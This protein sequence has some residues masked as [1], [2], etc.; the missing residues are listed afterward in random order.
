VNRAALVNDDAHVRRALRQLAGVNPKGQHHETR[1]VH[2]FAARMPLSVAEHF[3]RELAQPNAVVLDPMVGSGTTAVAT[4]RL[5]RSAVGI[6]RDPLA[7]LI[8]R[9]VT[10]TYSLKLVLQVSE[11][12][13][14]RARLLLPRKRAP[15][16]ATDET[17]QFIEYWFPVEAQQQLAA[18]AE[19]IMNEP[20]GAGRDFAWLV[21]SSSIIA[22]SAGASWAMDISRSRPHKREDKGVVLPFEAWSQRCT[23][24]AARLPFRDTRPAMGARIL[25]GDARNLPLEDRSVD[26]V[27]TSPPYLSAIDYLRSHRFSLVWMGFSMEVIRVLRATMVGTE[28][29]LWSPDGLPA[30]MEARLARV[31]TL[32][33]SRAHRRQYLSDLKKV[34]GEAARVVR[35]S[36]LVVMAVGPRILSPANDDAAA[37]VDSLVTDIG[38]RKVG[39]VTR[40]LRA[41]DRS[42]PFLGRGVGKVLS[43]RMRTEVFVALRKE[44]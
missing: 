18:L 22:K 6:D 26:M 11:R 40:H 14:K 15:V 30:P 27:L 33:R 37:V 25:G 16:M 24:A 20:P 35:A 38:L 36:G 9:V 19:S 1:W 3:V 39:S 7:L 13:L 31:V 10:T 29:G 23:T 17:R 5:G 8:S 2:P 21:F 43:R 42:L 41:A 4:L 28:R 34:L 32:Q 12:V 44:P